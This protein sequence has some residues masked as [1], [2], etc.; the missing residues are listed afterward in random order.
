MP[1]STH[2]PNSRSERNAADVA[3]SYLASFSTA[4]PDEI[5]AHVSDDFVNEHT[6]ALGSGCVGKDAYRSRLPSFLEDMTDLQYD[7]EQLITQGNEV[8]AFYTMTAR[9]KGTESI[10]VRG[11]KRLRITDGLITHRIDY[12]DSAVFLTQVSQ[13]AREALEPF[14]I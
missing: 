10:S 3:R 1:E 4:N 14:G 9:W 12:W 5:A 8:A 2:S 6:A 13:D 11:V 7:V